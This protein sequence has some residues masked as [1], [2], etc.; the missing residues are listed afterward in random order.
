M[1]L[2]NVSSIEYINSTLWQIWPAPPH[3]PFNFF[4]FSIIIFNHYISKT[5]MLNLPWDILFNHYVSSTP[6]FFLYLSSTA[7]LGWRWWLAAWCEVLVTVRFCDEFLS[8]P[9]S[10][11][12]RGVLSHSIFQCRLCGGWLTGNLIKWLN[13]LILSSFPHLCGLNHCS[14]CFV[15]D[16]V[17]F[18]LVSCPSEKSHFMLLLSL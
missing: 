6:I 1:H 9:L 13:H 12:R 15:S 17:T 14:D 18:S 10:N 2:T 11:I 5:L 4:F 7:T 8:H 16:H 3:T